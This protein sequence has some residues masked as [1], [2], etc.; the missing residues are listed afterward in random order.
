MSALPALF[1]TQEPDPRA[2]ARLDFSPSH[3]WFPTPR[4]LPGQKE[5]TV[6]GFA[7]CNNPGNGQ[8]GHTVRGAV[9]GGAAGLGVMGEGRGVKGG[10]QAL[11]PVQQV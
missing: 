4:P 10:L 6:K 7:P 5:G 3:P 9:R 2:G 11:D 1:S 8:R